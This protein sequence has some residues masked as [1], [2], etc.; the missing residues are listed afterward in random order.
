MFSLPSITESFLLQVVETLGLVSLSQ[1]KL[2]GVIAGTASLRAVRRH[3][4]ACLCRGGSS[5]QVCAVSPQR[6]VNIPA[7]SIQR[8]H[9]DGITDILAHV[10]FL[11]FVFKIYL[12]EVGERKRS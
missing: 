3:G 8:Q 9:P 6:R 7:R 11:S 2:L 5:L 1:I 10:H 12:L 4:L